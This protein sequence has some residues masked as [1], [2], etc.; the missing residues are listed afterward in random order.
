[1]RKPGHDFSPA[2]LYTQTT[3][4]DHDPLHAALGKY[5]NGEVGRRD[6]L[7]NSHAWRIAKEHALP[8]HAFIGRVSCYLQVTRT[9]TTKAQLEKIR[10]RFRQNIGICAETKFRPGRT[11]PRLTSKKSKNFRQLSKLEQKEATVRSNLITLDRKKIKPEL[12][13]SQL[14][15]KKYEELS[16]K[17]LSQTLQKRMRKSTT[18]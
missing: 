4:P 7:K 9:I 2:W 12:N 16:P 10:T 15:R 14:R 8:V 6:V 11:R 18:H 17:P 5:I 1:M 13:L 3:I